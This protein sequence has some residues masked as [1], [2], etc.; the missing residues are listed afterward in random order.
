MNLYGK[1]KKGA[2]ENIAYGRKD[3]MGVIQAF[4]IDQGVAGKVHR[5]N[6]FNPNMG[7]VGIYSGDH[8]KFGQMTCVDYARSFTESDGSLTKLYDDA[9]W[10]NAYLI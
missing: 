5:K 1:W 4:L 8:S 10:G 7:V 6:L 2:S 3:A 9:S